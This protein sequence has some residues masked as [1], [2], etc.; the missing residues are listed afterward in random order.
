M[1]ELNV[2]DEFAS[3]HYL[4]GY[5]GKC[6]RVHGH[7]YRV[8]ITVKAKKLNK[9][10][11]A[12]D[13]SEIKVELKKNMEI[14]DHRLLDELPCFKKVNPSAENIA[15]YIFDSMNK[16]LKVKQVKLSKVTVWETARASASYS[17]E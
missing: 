15:K 7:N 6:E 10:G 8:M 11:L 4:R 12:V 1:Y 13:F 17:N 16:P 14:L 2:E 5:K 9:I 3:A